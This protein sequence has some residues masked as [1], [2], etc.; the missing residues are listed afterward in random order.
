MLAVTKNAHDE[1]SLK[2]QLAKKKTR[3]DSSSEC[4]VVFAVVSMTHIYWLI[5]IRYCSQMLDVSC[6]LV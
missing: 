6:L 2:A 4:I 5:L 1:K 3:N